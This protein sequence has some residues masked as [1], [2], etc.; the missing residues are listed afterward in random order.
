M[1]FPQSTMNI[2][3]LF[4][5][6]GK[7][8]IIFMITAEEARAKMAENLVKK[9][10]PDWMLTQIES[11]I[12]E[13]IAIEA[14][15]TEVEIIFPDKSISFDEQVNIFYRIKEFLSYKGFNTLYSVGLYVQ[16]IAGAIYDIRW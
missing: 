13:A 10:I 5:F 4:T 1:A 3:T 2:Y 9:G 8:K 11:K 15:A 12:K 6:H 7:E 14:T 16:D